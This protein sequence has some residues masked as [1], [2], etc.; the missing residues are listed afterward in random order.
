MQ[1]IKAFT[2]IEL[3]ITIAIV[4]ILAAIAIPSYGHYLKRARFSGVIT[5]SSQYKTAVALALQEGVSM[6]D[7]HLGVHGIPDAPSATKN[8]ASLDVKRGVITATGTKAAG[9]YTYILKPDADGSHWDVSGT[10][11]AAGMCET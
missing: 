2:L 10:C 8:L 4:G 5:A 9:G 6:K 3:L 7:L 1:T 11:V